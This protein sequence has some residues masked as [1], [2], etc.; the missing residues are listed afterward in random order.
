MA[1]GTGTRTEKGQ[2]KKVRKE[3]YM[4]TFNK[5]EVIIFDFGLHFI[6]QCPYYFLHSLYISVN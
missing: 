1:C 6:V 2:D 5:Q 4:K 3:N